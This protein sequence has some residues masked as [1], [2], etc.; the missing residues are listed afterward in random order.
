MP[1]ALLRTLQASACCDNVV[2]AQL[3]QTKEEFGSFISQ[4]RCGFQMTFKNQVCFCYVYFLLMFSQQE[5]ETFPL[6]MTGLYSPGAEWNAMNE[7]VIVLNTFDISQPQIIV[8]TKQPYKL[9]VYL[10]LPF[11]TCFLHHKRLC[12]SGINEA[13]KRGI[14]PHPNRIYA[15]NLLRHDKLIIFLIMDTAEPWEVGA[16][17]KAQAEGLNLFCQNCF[18]F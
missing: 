4:T 2:T 5:L 11:Q 1:A 17:L 3:K 13:F 10:F 12:I 15:S 18:S 16:A 6:K 8:C 7:N 9:P 14:S